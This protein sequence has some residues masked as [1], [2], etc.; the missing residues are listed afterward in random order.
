MRALPNN[1][2]RFPLIR[3]VMPE[4]AAWLP[5]LKSAY[6]ARYFT[7][8][9]PN[10]QLL[11]RRLAER[12]GNHGSEVVLTSNATVALTAALFAMGVNGNVAVP[13][14][15]F[16]A[17]MQ[18]IIA[19]GC[20]PIL[21]DV[22]PATWEITPEILSDAMSRHTL[23]AVM[24]VRVFGLVR[25]HSELVS[26]ALKHDVQV[27]TDAAA[28]LGHVRFNIPPNEARYVEVFSLH[29]TKSFAIGEGGAIPLRPRGRH[30][31]SQS[32]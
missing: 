19:A 14:F 31:T 29:A 26:L 10:E 18:A 25:D 13:A 27:I 1:G 8:F 20:H 17:T 9:G 32:H 24:P 15:T 5:Y 11:C 6:D 22:D 7:N 28:A 30:E 21:L 2:I 4:P 12:F 3:P 23:A 16:P